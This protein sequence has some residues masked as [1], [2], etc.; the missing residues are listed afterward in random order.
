MEGVVKS[1][2]KFANK[3]LHTSEIMVTGFCRVRGILYLNSTIKS[4][5]WSTGLPF[6]NH[7]V[8]L[9]LQITL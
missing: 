2:N 1:L 3:G 7:V 9:I 4:S 5:D 8:L 6:E